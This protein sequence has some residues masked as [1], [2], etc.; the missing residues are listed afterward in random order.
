MGESRSSLGSSE[1]SATSGVASN[2]LRQLAGLIAEQKAMGSAL[3]RI[4]AAQSALRSR[5]ELLLG[6][7]VGTA[8]SRSAGHAHALRLSAGAPGGLGARRPPR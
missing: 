6:R 2:S 8:R 4:E 7:M 5:L 1:S 3:E